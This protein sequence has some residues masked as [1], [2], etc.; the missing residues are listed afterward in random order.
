MINKI[1]SLY[2]LLFLIKEKT[3]YQINGNKINQ[4]DLIINLSVRIRDMLVFS[5]DKNQTNSALKLFKEMNPNF[6]ERQITILFNNSSLIKCLYF[7]WSIY[8]VMDFDMSYQALRYFGNFNSPEAPIYGTEF[9]NNYIALTL[10]K[11][12]NPKDRIVVVPFIEDNK[13]N[14]KAENSNESWI[15][16]D[17]YALPMLINK[18]SE[19]YLGNN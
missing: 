17:P 12:L 3:F 13:L 8:G 19:Y 7:I 14:F 18:V 9:A 10:N 4:K 6:S 2:Y 15:F 11:S 16:S 5:I 1:K